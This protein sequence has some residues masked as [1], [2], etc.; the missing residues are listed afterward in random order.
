[1]PENPEDHEIP[2]LAREIEGYLRQKPD[3]AD[4]LQGIVTWWLGYQ[5]YVYTR[6]KIVQALNELISKGVMKKEIG[7]FVACSS[8]SPKTVNFY[9]WQTYFQAR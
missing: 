6:E 9:S 5:R 8:G 7:H 4:T 1:M 2:I 3:R